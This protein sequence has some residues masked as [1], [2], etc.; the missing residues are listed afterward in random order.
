MKKENPQVAKG[1]LK[2]YAE[3][4]GR[5]QGLWIEEARWSLYGYIKI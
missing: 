1:R 4:H 5:V 3:R 2:N